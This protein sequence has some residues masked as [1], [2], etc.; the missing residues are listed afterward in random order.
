[1]LIQGRPA[2]AALAA[3]D[4]FVFASDPASGQVLRTPAG[5]VGPDGPAI[6][7]DGQNA[8]ALALDQ[9]SVYWVD[10]ARRAVMK[11]P[12]CLPAPAAD[13]TP[14]AGTGDDSAGAA[15]T[16]VARFDDQQ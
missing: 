4:T 11:A 6:V 8:A 15:M 1:T 3:D 12:R 2:I 16:V 9:S 5:G 7:A 13:P 14:P 10:T